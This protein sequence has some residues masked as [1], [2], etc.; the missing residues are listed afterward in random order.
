MSF[1]RN[2]FGVFAAVVA[3]SAIM[4]PPASAAEPGTISTFAGDGTT[5]EHNGPPS[6]RYAIGHARGVAVDRAG[7]RYYSEYYEPARIMKIDAAGVLS[8]VCTGCGGIGLAVDKDGTLFSA[9]S[10]S[11]YRISPQG[12]RTLIAGTPGS[13]GFAGD[14]GPATSALLDGSWDVAVDDAGNVYLTDTYN[15][16]VRK[17]DTSGIIRTIA[18]G[19]LNLG[20]GGPATS[21]SIGSPFGVAVDHAGNVFIAA[22]SQNRIRMV[23]TWGFISTIAGTGQS[24][25]SGDG[26][27]AT[28]AQFRGPFDVTLDDA[29]NLYVNDQYNIRTRRIDRAGH[30]ITT[31]AGNGQAGYGGDNGPATGAMLGLHAEGTAVDPAGR[32]LYIGDVD[33]YR[34]RQ[35]D[36][37]ANVITT[38]AGT[39]VFGEST[40]GQA[41]TASLNA[42]ANTALDKAGNLYI[43]DD[44]QNFIRK[45]DPA[46][47][48]SVFAGNGQRGYTGD[49]GPATWAQING[50]WGITADNAGNVYF[51]DYDQRV[52]KV[53]TAG[54]ISTVGAFALPR[55]VVTD[56]AGNLYVA[57][58]NGNRVLKVTPGGTIT[59][60][61][62]N[63]TLGS[64]GDNG[65]ATNACLNSPT[66]LA[67]DAAGAL[68][69]VETNGE[70]V[71][72]VSG[73]VITTVAGRG[74]AG[75]S[76]DLGPATQAE[77]HFPSGV[78][79][80]RSGN[81]YIADTSNGRVRMVQAD[82][83]IRTVAGNGGDGF[84]GDGGPARSASVNGVSGVTVDAA[85]TLYLADQYNNRIRKV[86]APPPLPAPPV[87]HDDAFDMQKGS[88]VSGNVIAN[89]TGDRVT[90]LQGGPAHSGT[91]SFGPT[92]FGYTPAGPWVTTDWFDYTIQDSAGQTSTARVYLGSALS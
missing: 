31:V 4:V 50:P 68:Y 54:R 34:L 67:I 69:I 80:D 87:A 16:R 23:D 24:G 84:T 20:D 11:V 52:R 37:A 13:H 29:G 79:V 88:P 76:G 75:F 85:G 32:Y 18:G 40:G 35:V 62:G 49:G 36:L 3:A 77:L 5:L 89:D 59:P 45:V 43:A 22:N 15:Y 78:A 81:L 27:P 92:G 71:R 1:A 56:A 66:G 9:D 21:A 8:T 51:S 72:K 33:N 19:G 25:Y 47:N 14:G 2:A 39:G 74:T 28:A 90:V 61:A 73:G 55:G 26:G 65:P 91:V 64:C 12:V 70:R 41:T 63:G 38:L 6:A 86:T 30:V 83:R 44:L 57:E 82:G 53:D 10:D 7:N 17:V 46:G 42:P 48:I 58:W 60:F